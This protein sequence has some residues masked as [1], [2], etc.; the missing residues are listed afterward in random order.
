MNHLRSGSSR[1]T[2]ASYPASPSSPSAIRSPVFQSRI[3]QPSLETGLPSMIRR[4]AALNLVSSLEPSLVGTKL[5]LKNSPNVL[6]NDVCAE[7]GGWIRRRLGHRC[8]RAGVVLA[9]LCHLGADCACSGSI[10]T[11]HHVLRR[12]PTLSVR[13]AYAEIHPASA[14]ACPRTRPAAWALAARSRAGVTAVRSISGGTSAGVRGKP[15]VAIGCVEMAEQAAVVARAP[16]TV[17]RGYRIPSIPS[18][19]RHDRVTACARGCVC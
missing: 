13:M 18:T 16:A 3:S 8:G 7:V 17:R 2:V 9:G 15:S 6:P 14:T 10:A 11:A 4:P 5:W 12:S 1:A 19:S